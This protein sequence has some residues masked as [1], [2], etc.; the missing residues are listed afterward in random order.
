M[1]K[2]QGLPR[3]C[4][5]PA[6]GW[7]PAKSSFFGRACARLLRLLR[8]RLLVALSGSTHSR[9][10]ARPHM[11]TTSVT[12]GCSLFHIRLQAEDK[13]MEMEIARSET[14]TCTPWATL[15][16]TRTPTPNP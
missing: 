10:E 7:G 16:L 2:V 1:V 8:A 6:E 13:K 4:L 3:A 9:G 11:V 12:Y 15:T 5:G 14:G